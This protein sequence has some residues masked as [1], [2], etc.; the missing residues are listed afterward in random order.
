MKE[1]S[2][3]VIVHGKVIPNYYVTN[4]G[5]VFYTDKQ[6]Q[7]KPLKLQIRQHNYYYVCL[8]FPKTLFSDYSY[9]TKSKNTCKLN[10]DVHKLVMNA[11]KP[12]DQYPPEQL[13]HCWDNLPPEVKQWVKDTVTINHIDHDKTNNWLDNLEYCTPKHNSRESVKY[14]TNKK[15]TIIEQKIEYPNTTIFDFV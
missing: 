15:L 13:K 4:T 8:Y 10:V 14:H 11:F 7:L 3:P 1:E 12:V 6:G 9:D 5:K 2:K